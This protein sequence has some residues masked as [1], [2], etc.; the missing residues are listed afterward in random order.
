MIDEKGTKKRYRSKSC[1]FPRVGGGLCVCARGGRG[2]GLREKVCIRDTGHVGAGGPS[3]RRIS[4]PG[5]YA[6]LRYHV[7]P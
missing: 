2:E 6:R 7:S 3:L 4:T 5:R 1:S